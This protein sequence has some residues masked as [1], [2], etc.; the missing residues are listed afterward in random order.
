MQP[1]SL[2]SIVGPGG[3]LLSAIV[4]DCFGMSPPQ[5]TLFSYLLDCP[6][7]PSTLR[8]WELYWILCISPQ[9]GTPGCP[10]L[11]SLSLLQGWHIAASSAHVPHPQSP[12]KELEQ[13][14]HIAVIWPREKYLVPGGCW[15]FPWERFLSCW[16]CSMCIF[17]SL[18][19]TSGPAL[20]S[21]GSDFLY[22]GNILEMDGLTVHSEA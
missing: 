6:L 9:L 20:G 11:K 17:Q 3:V 16:S 12:P 1:W 21:K 18:V 13:R 8:S 22:S 5:M 19:A 15:R 14:R 4:N 7:I 10:S 2:V